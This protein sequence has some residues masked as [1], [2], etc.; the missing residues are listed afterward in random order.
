MKLSAMYFSKAQEHEIWA[1]RTTKTRRQGGNWVQ[2]QYLGWL[3]QSPASSSTSS[4]FRN[5]C[6]FNFTRT[7]D[8]T[9]WFC[10][11]VFLWVIQWLCNI[12]EAWQ[13]IEDKA[14]WKL[15]D[16]PHYTRLRL[17]ARRDT[18]SE[19]NEVCLDPNKPPESREAC[20][21]R[22]SVEI[23]I[24]EYILTLERV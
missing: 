16:V 2:G 24:Y 8:A 20:M 7:A 12:L 18:P 19:Q 4:G 5:K 6:V 1:V 23:C 10:C 21:C 9:S 14:V 22:R 15:T 17:S 13:Q 11:L 3:Y